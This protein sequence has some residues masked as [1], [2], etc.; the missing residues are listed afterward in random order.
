MF[1]HLA[2]L[3]ACRGRALTLSV[4]TTGSTSLSATTTGYA[5]AAGSFVA[6]GF[7]RGDEIAVSGFATAANNGQGII[8]DVTA[9]AITLDSAYTVTLTPAGYVV[10]ARTLVTEA[11]AAGRTISVGLPALRAFENVALTPV[12]GKPFV[13]EDYLPGPANQFT[14]GPRGWIEV[15][16]QYVLKLYAPPNTGVT[17]LY[18]AA[19]ALL[20]LFTPGTALTL[21]TGDVLRVRTDVAPY[22][23]QLL[24]DAAGFAVVVITVPLRAESLNTI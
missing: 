15:T 9:G 4:N 3:L 14:T 19:D 24:Q 17:A 6:D 13:E 8:K 23:G 10:A 16:P 12:A 2:A 22:R 7:S 11:A 5:R 20:T 21:S 18:K 1:S